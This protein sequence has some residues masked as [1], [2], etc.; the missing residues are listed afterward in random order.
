M[1]VL[2]CVTISGSTLFSFFDL[3]SFS[4]IIFF[5]FC[6]KGEYDKI[7]FFFCYE[8]VLLESL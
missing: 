1:V 4:N 6:A 7:Y 2:Y 8:L 3:L 5:E